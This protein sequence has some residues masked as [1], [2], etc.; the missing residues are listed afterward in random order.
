MHKATSQDFTGKWQ[1]I[2]V[3]ASKQIDTKEQR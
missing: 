2:G 1:V 3:I